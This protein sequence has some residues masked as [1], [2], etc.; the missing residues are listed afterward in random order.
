[1]Q[2]ETAK[3]LDTQLAEAIEGFKSH[4]IRS[5][6]LAS[7]APGRVNLIGEH[8]DY[9]EGFVF[10]MAI[11]RQAVIVAA[12]RP[13]SQ[14]NI[15]DEHAEGV[16][17]F[18]LA[19]PLQ[20][21]KPGWANYIKGVLAGFQAHDMELPGFDAYICNTVPLGGGLSSSAALEVAT[22]TLGEQLAGQRIDPVEK[23]LLCQKAE[24]DFAGMP[25]GIMDQ[26]ISVMGQADHAMLLDCRSHEP[27][28]V[29]ME[30]ASV[31]VLIINS[32]KKHE[33]TGS[34]YP[35]RRQQCE[36][37][38]K[39]LGVKALRDVTMPQLI[40][41]KPML[42]P[43]VFQRAYHVVGENERTE[44]AADMLEAGDYEGMGDLMF[45]SHTAMQG[46]FEITIDEIDYLVKL[47]EEKRGQGGVYGSRMTGGGF[48]GCTVTLVRTDKAEEVARHIG[49]NYYKETG[50]EPTCF[51]SR[52]AD[53]TRPIKL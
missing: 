51:I 1:M 32:N 38:A 7:V 41:A 39:A 36:T 43:K 18:D 21:G 26:F 11:E 9:N 46:A 53:G 6:E 37:A 22:A 15:A 4:F 8:T 17:T 47:A 33:L 52:P 30:D 19:D 3:S 13:D 29:P 2:L 24:H 50:I 45:Q 5:P 12:A 10:P 20:P 28:L 25:C 27:R 34:E 40:Q 31:T 35:E 44:R 42:D 49:V 16:L 14:V 23:A 48:G